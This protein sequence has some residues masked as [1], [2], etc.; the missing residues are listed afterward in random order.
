MTSR[1]SLMQ[2]CAPQSF[3]NERLIAR[4]Q[5]AVGKER[6]QQAAFIACLSEVSRRKLHLSRGYSSLYDFC[7]NHFQLSE[8]GIY[9]RIQVANAASKYPMIL[10]FL[11]AGRL[12]LTVASLICPYLN[13]ENANELLE[14]SS[15]MTRRQAESYIAL[16]LADSQVSGQEVKAGAVSAVSV[17]QHKLDRMHRIERE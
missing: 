16:E 2:R 8:G 15:G 1:P 6:E 9:R 10:D 14:K 7:L 12:S 11:A 5:E 17:F 13:A 3:N 4:M